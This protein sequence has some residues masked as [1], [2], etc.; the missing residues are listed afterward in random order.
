M[1]DS[2]AATYAQALELD[3][4]Y[5]HSGYQANFSHQL[6]YIEGGHEQITNAAGSWVDIGYNPGKLTPNIWHH[7]VF[8]Y[9][10]NTGA[11]TYSWVSLELDGVITNI[12][13]TLQ[14]QPMY[15]STWPDGVI[16]QVQ[17]DLT[18][19]AGQFTMKIQNMQLTWW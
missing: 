4:K 17:Q 19:A 15:A 18:V 1:V 5:T 14:N 9:S 13:N 3:C 11:L 6:N 7:Y 2:Y 10:F 12:P 16:P 8:T